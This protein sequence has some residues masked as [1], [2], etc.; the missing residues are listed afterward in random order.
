[1]IVLFLHSD[2]KDKMS[3][4]L[5]VKTVIVPEGQNQ[6]GV[7][8]VRFTADYAASD[9]F[10]QCIGCYP[11]IRN[12][13][14]MTR[15]KGG[16]PANIVDSTCEDQDLSSCNVTPTDNGGIRAFVQ[17]SL[18]CC[19]SPDDDEAAFSY[20]VGTDALHSG[21]RPRCQFYDQGW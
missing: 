10:V 12:D 7:D 8:V 13:L 1:M 6:H 21:G 11:P 2:I 20:L 17:C 19:V 4:P 5:S 3:Q 18:P 16:D 9:I 15:G 14:N